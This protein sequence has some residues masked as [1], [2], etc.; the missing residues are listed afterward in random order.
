[1]AKKCPFLTL[2]DLLGLFW[3][4]IMESG[5]SLAAHEFQTNA[6]SN[7]FEVGRRLNIASKN[8]TELLEVL[9]KED[10]KELFAAATA[11]SLISIQF[12][13]LISYLLIITTSPLLALLSYSNYDAFTSVLSSALK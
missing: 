12:K 9:Q 8:S 13:I 5:S 6:S 11:V 3:A 10:T 7:A 1:M 4:G 2:R